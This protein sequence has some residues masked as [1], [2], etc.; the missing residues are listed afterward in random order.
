MASEQLNTEVGT[1][2]ESAIAGVVGTLGLKTDVFIAQLLNFL[3]ILFVLWRWAYKPLLKIL[4][5][6]EV[7]IKKG[8]DDA[9]AAGARLADIEKEHVA[10]LARAREEGAV[11]IKDAH[12]RADEKREELLAKSRAEISKLVTDARKKIADERATAAE[13]LK[14]EIAALVVTTAEMVLKER[15]DADKDATI[16]N[17][18]LKKIKKSK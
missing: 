11:F 9:D 17:K 2:P 6:R 4:E 7:R 12:A 13:E 16:M 10:V 8:L 18:S 3:I 1:A 14:K 15:I 5:E